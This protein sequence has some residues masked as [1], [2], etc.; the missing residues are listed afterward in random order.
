MGRVK[1]MLKVFLSI[2][3]AAPTYAS[4]LAAGRR[5][6]RHFDYDSILIIVDYGTEVTE[7]LIIFDYGRMPVEL[8]F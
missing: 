4:H 1:Y 5:R 6:L 7:R 8:F 3:P 2:T